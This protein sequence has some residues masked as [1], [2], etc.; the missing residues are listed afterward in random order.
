MSLENLI[1]NFM[2]YEVQLEARKKDEQQP[3]SKK[4]ELAFHASSDTYNSDDDKE[5]MT[6]LS[7]KFRKFLKKGKFNPICFNFNKT[8][9][10]KKDCPLLKNKSKFKSKKFRKK[11]DY[12][13]SW[14]NGDSSSSDEEETTEHANICYMALEEDEVQYTELLDAFHELLNDL[15]LSLIHI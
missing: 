6:M 4:K 5:E 3:L 2:A 1:G 10:M 15:K 7:R 14:E 12:Q 9:H 11:K 8:G 13:A